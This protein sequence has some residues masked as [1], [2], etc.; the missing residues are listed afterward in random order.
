M[1]P[2]PTRYTPTAIWLH[3]I[4]GA[5]LLMMF[6]LGFWMHELP[7]E[8]KVGA[9]DLFNW[10]LYTITFAEPTSLRTFYFN[11]HKSIGVTLLALILFRVVWR[12]QHAAP[13]FPDTMQTWEK[14]V[15]DGAHKLMYVLMVALP[16]SGMLMATY[17]KYGI[18]WF[19]IPLIEGLDQPELREGF[20]EAHEIIGLTLLA[21]IVLHVLAAIK[22]KVLD[23]DG[24]M[25]RMSLR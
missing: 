24:I 12:V 9:I 17:S 11:L 13:A 21:L 1:K 25:A 16:L 10:G 8:V 4:I 22:H 6:A 2:A 15:A 14:K 5:L 7:K 19:G 23:R 18:V 3:W 20:K